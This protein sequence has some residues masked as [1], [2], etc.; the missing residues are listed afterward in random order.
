MLIRPDAKLA[1]YFSCFIVSD[2]FYDGLDTFSACPDQPSSFKLKDTAAEDGVD[3]TDD[4]FAVKALLDRS[5]IA[6][7]A[8]K[9]SV[10][11]FAADIA[12]IDIPAPSFD[13]EH[14]SCPLLVLDEDIIGV[15]E[16]FDDFFAEDIHFFKI[17]V[18]QAFHHIDRQTGHHAHSAVFHA[19]LDHVKSKGFFFDSRFKH[20]GDG[21]RLHR[22]LFEE[23][24]RFN[25]RP[26]SFCHEISCCF[27]PNLTGPV[28]ESF[29]DLQLFLI[30]DKEESFSLPEAKRVFYSFFCG[31]IKLAR[32][33]CSSF[34]TLFAFT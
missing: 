8:G 9:V 22:Q 10:F 14:N 4:Q 16:G 15:F 25:D 20:I 33:H 3:K 28:G 29:G 26:Q 34:F 24:G 30:G 23:R 31:L 27:C 1:D 2:I 18:D 6:L 21:C 11:S 7:T 13:A 12:P 19:D 5:R 32:F 17:D